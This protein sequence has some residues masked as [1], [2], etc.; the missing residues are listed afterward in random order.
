MAELDTITIPTL[1]E[2][3][4]G[5]LRVRRNGL[6]QRGVANP[7][8]TRS[9]DHYVYATALAINIAPA[10]QNLGIMSD[11]QMPDTAED[12]YLIRQLTTYGL[13]VP[14]AVGSSGNIVFAASSASLVP[15][16][17]QLVDDL[18]QVYEVVTGGTYVDGNEIPIR[19]VTTGKSTDHVSGDALQWVGGVP[20]FA[21]NVALVGPGGLTGGADEGDNSSNRSLLYSHLRNP[22]GGG[23]WSQIIAWAKAASP[24]VYSAF[25]YPALNGPATVGLVLLGP[26]SYDSTNGFTREV[27]ETVRSLVHDYVAAQIDAHA[28]VNLTTQTPKEA[29]SNAVDVSVAI[30]VSLPAAIGAGG[31]GG[32]WV[33]ATPWPVLLGTATR[34]YVSAVTDSTHITITSNDAGTTPSAVGI[35]DGVTEVA[36]FDAQGYADGN[37]AVR[38]AVVTAHGGSTGAITLT[39]SEPFPDIATNDFVFPSSERAE[40]YAQAF[41][42]AMSN[43]GPGQ[44]YSNLSLVP[45]A[46]RRPL[47]AQQQT[48]DMAA[49]L[50]K[51]ITDSGEEVE[52][53]AYLYRSSTSPAVPVSTTAS[54]KTFVPGTLGFFDKIP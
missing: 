29:D 23:N 32:G 31:P 42:L 18:G 4:D 41:L 54:P 52:D 51:P 36:W 1:D 39:L 34:V 15:T 7:N 26:M 38:T 35:Q 11:Q 27:T 46:A 6:I 25:V 12:E 28:H 10:Y 22:A 3:R 14:S 16:G 20:G 47:I 40:Q 53:V 13:E 30:G 50:L 44:W 48:S 17:K 8:V 21:D 9:S 45:Q 19:G 37:A 24:S 43:M 2:L 5:N 49:S 33:N